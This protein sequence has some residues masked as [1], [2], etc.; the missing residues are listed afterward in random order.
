ME[1]VLVLV[2][3]HELSLGIAQVFLGDK[4]K[5]KTLKR[6]SNHMYYGEDS[7]LCS[8]E[9]FHDKK[10]N[11]KKN[12]MLALAQWLI[13]LEPRAVHQKAAGLIPGEG[14]CL[15]CGLDSQSGRI[16]EATD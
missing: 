6:H 1:S 9:N 12:H 8:L 13:W 10:L 7:D 11:K 2:T 15:S 4:E 14:T 5:K 16:P 3:S